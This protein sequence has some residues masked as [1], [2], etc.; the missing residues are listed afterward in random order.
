[1]LD[2]IERRGSFAKAAEEIDKATS[3][4]S[5]GVQK[6]EDQFGFAIFRRDGRRSVL[7]PAGRFL[8]EE[9][10][11]ILNATAEL[12]EKTKEVATGWEPRLKVAVES[13]VDYSVFFQ[14]IAD[15]LAEHEGLEID[16]TECVL[17][18]GWE[19][20]EHD[21]VDLLVGVPAP[22]PLKRGYRALSIG[23]S[24]LLPVI[25][26]RHPFAKSAL[27]PKVLATELA[28]LR[29]VVSHDTSLLNVVRSVGLSIGSS[30]VLYV[31]TVDQKVEAV[32]SGLGIA[33]LP[34]HRIQRY[35]DSGVLV[36]LEIDSFNPEYFVA[37]KLANKGMAL[38]TLSKRLADA[39]W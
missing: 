11:K 26:T 34:R 21:R 3:A 10:R 7:T 19:A 1:M 13:V 18:G 23:H 5:Y 14:V 17:N 22:V 31:Q 2:A 39:D 28:N 29:R 35:L 32:V 33:H 38:K 12:A 9:G 20:L 15:F 36:Q 6:L 30:N 4:L 8:L 16:V 27:D 25:G 37:W 24:N